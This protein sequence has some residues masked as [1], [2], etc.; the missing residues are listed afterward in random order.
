M[1]FIRISL[2]G[3]FYVLITLYMVINLVVSNFIILV[4][5]QDKAGIKLKEVRM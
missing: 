1:H 2:W 4:V 3:I 5:L